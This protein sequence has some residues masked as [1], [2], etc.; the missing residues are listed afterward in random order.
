MKKIKKQK[1]KKQVVNNKKPIQNTTTTTNYAEN[2]TLTNKSE[3]AQ[4]EKKVVKDGATVLFHYRKKLAITGA[5]IEDSRLKKSV[6]I[7]VGGNQIIKS[8]EKGMLGMSVGETKEFFI[9]AAEAHGE[10]T[11]DD[12]VILK[13]TQISKNFNYNVGQILTFNNLNGM[14]I[15]AEILKITPTSVILNTNHPLAGEDLFFEAEI[16]DIV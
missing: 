14:N 1:T 9:P 5:V 3:P 11:T 8:F 6:K 10:I 13:K 4:L 16:L 2:K 15:A 12:I 7:V